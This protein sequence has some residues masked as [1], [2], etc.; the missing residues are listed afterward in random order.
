M[1]PSLQQKQGCWLLL[2]HGIAKSGDQ[3]RLTKSSQTVVNPTHPKRVDN[4]VFNNVARL[5]LDNILLTIVLNDLSRGDTSPFFSLLATTH[6]P[7]QQGHADS[8][9]ATGCQ[10]APTPS[11]PLNIHTSTV[12]LAVA[13]NDLTLCAAV[14]PVFH[15]THLHTSRTTSWVRLWRIACTHALLTPQS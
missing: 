12:E 13:S 10:L 15:R 4:L 2:K 14:C 8:Q 11:A 1:R 5:E 6:T 3:Y 7:T 9:R